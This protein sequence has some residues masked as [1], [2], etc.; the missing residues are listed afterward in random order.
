[1][2]IAFCA[3]VALAILVSLVM[4]WIQ[5]GRISDLESELA[6]IKR[7]LASEQTPIKPGELNVPASFKVEN[8]TPLQSKN[9]PILPRPIAQ[10]VEEI[11]KPKI[12]FEQRFGARLPVCIGGAALALSG[13]FLVKYSI[14][15][16]ILTQNVRLILGAA[17]G[18]SLMRLSTWI[19][20]YDQIANNKKIAQTLAGA[21]I[22]DLYFCIYAATSLYQIF[23]PFLG[24][25][26]M[27]CVTAIAVFMSLRFG[28]AIAIFGLVGGFLTP[29]LISSNEPSAALLFFYLYLLF[30]GLFFVIRKQNWWVLAIPSV[31]AVFLWVIIWLNTHFNP[32]DS[33]YLGLFLIAICATTVFNSQA[34]IE[35]GEVDKSH[36]F[37]LSAILSYITLGGATLLLEMITKQSNCGILELSLFGVLAIGSIF[38]AYFKQKIYGLAPL[39]TCAASALILLSCPNLNLATILAFAILFTA[40]GYLL[41]WK[42]A[43]PKLWA[44]LVGG[45]SVAYYAIGYLKIYQPINQVAWSITALIL[46]FLAAQIT[47]KI[48][49]KFPNEESSKQQL[50]AIFAA[51]SCAFLTMSFLIVLPQEFFPIFFAA[52]ILALSWINNG[53]DVKA[54]RKI[55]NVCLVIFGILV[56]V[57]ILNS[58]DKSLIYFVAPALMMFLASRLFVRK[59]D[60]RLVQYLEIFTVTLAVAAAYFTLQNNFAISFTRRGIFTDILCIYAVIC[61]WFGKKFDRRVFLLSTQVLFYAAILRVCAF[62]FL[63]LNPIWS[64]QAVGNLPLINALILPY[65]L[66]AGALIF[67]NRTQPLPYSKPFIL[68]SIFAFISLNVRQLF[69]SPYLDFGTTSNA[70]TYSYSAAWLIFGIVALFIGTAQKN[71]SIRLAAL[72][73]ITLA[74]CKVFLYDASELTG[75]YRVFS[76]LGLGIVLIGLSW[77]YTRFLSEEK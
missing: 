70:E 63:S 65:L 49:A 51:T 35:N 36:N 29:A 2:F 9:I 26:A 23:P 62:D 16:G 52:Q 34:A 15:A 4:P 33:L 76:F 18:F 37:S 38:L 61:L 44:I 1:M 64:H 58:S 7:L 66:P 27:T 43:S 20:S 41:L 72:G 11:A 67:A 6:R 57:Q 10:P 32:A 39:I 54:L 48:N 8:P 60:D 17:F 5:M 75:L 53:V 19:G 50:L 42:S 24:I 30:A 68:V 77:F 25:V 14:D 45:A 3:V 59:G 73:L 55:A 21:A 71:K 56:A 40:S 12:S 74:V 28:A 47:K 13:L 46:A 22:V 31:I 69:H